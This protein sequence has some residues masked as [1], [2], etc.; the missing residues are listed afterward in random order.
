MCSHEFQYCLSGDPNRPCFVLRFKQTTI[1][2]DCALDV[3]SLLHFLPLNV[4]NRSGL[5]RIQ[6]RGKRE[7][8]S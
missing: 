8:Q 7:T 6:G 1:M 2:L 3:T 5:Q 4:I